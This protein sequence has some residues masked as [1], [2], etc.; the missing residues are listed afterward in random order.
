MKLLSLLVLVVIGALFV[1]KERSPVKS[2]ELAEEKSEPFTQL[3]WSDEFDVEGGLDTSRWFHQTKLPEQ[4]F[5]WGGIVQHYTDEET[6]TFV[7]DGKLHLVAKKEKYTTHGETKDYTAARL[8]SKFA[9]TYGRVEVRAK[10]P[11]GV[12]TWPAIWMLNQNIAE[13]GAYWEELGYGTTSWPHCGEIDIMEHWGKNHGYVSSALHNGS[14]YGG[15][16]KNVAGRMVEN[17]S[18]DFHIYELVWTEKQMVFSIDGIEHYTYRPKIKNKKT[19]PYDTNYYL[20]LN[21]AIEPEIDPDFQESA[22]VVDYV[23]V[24]Q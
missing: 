10:M 8:N 13:D 6:N 15:H 1:S 4:G 18:E 11:K 12:G 19:W 17:V 23:R 2:N 7:R 21:I 20:L 9:F 24:Y 3:V 22:M 14:S 5:W 16:V